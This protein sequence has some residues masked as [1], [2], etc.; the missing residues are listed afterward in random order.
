[1]TQGL[2]LLF[3]ED[4]PLTFDQPVSA[5]LLGAPLSTHQ[6]LVVYTFYIPTLS[7]LFPISD[8]H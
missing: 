7:P 3:A 5:G 1:M 6:D 8:E 4:R 2:S